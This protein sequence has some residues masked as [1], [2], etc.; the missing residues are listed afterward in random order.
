M[1]RDLSEDLV[2]YGPDFYGR[3]AEFRK[4]LKAIDQDH[5]RDISADEIDAFVRTKPALAARLEQQM[6][7]LQC[8]P[9]SPS[10][11]SEE[12]IGKVLAISGLGLVFGGP[13]LILV[14]S[15]GAAMLGSFFIAAI[16][17]GMLIGGVHLNDRANAERRHAEATHVERLRE[18]IR[19]TLAKAAP[20]CDEFQTRSRK[21]IE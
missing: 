5:T 12:I 17:L 10:S 1:L 13:L 19:A 18:E 8:R 14:T 20:K 21:K 2:M 9:K 4:T 16:G 6:T 7:E 3:P 11:A 15:A